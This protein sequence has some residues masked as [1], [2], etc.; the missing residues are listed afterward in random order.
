MGFFGTKQP[1]YNFSF[2]DKE[3]R[4]V[5]DDFAIKLDSNEKNILE[6]G[7][8]EEKIQTLLQIRR[9]ENHYWLEF[10]RTYPVSVFVVSPQREVLEWN[11]Y[12]EILTKWNHNELQNVSHA[13]EILWPQNPKECKVCKIVGKYDTKEK[14][15]GFDYAELEDKNGTIIPVF[16][17]VI[18]IFV[19][20]RLDRTYCII[21]DRREEISQRKEFLNSEIAPIVSRLEGL[22]QK[23]IQALISLKSDSELTALQEPIND[24]IRTLQDIINKIQNAATTIN[25]E[26]STAKNTLD[27]SVNWAQSEFQPTQADL[28]EKAKSLE[29]LTTDIESMVN[30]IK[31]IADQT[32]LLALNAAIEAARAGEHGR[33]FAVV[34]DEVRKLAENSHKSTIEITSSIS[35]IKDASF[36]MV[37]D[38]QKANDDTQKLIDELTAV[39]SNVNNIDVNILTL[40]EEVDTFKQ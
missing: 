39:H 4:E 28:V 29:N 6:N 20:S 24:I 2:L 15:A 23:D 5:V 14:K 32:N 27:S 1:A 16:V 35:M 18:P 17:Y 22:R 21:R 26:S 40:K 11:N 31:D 37:N 33:G 13:S 25:Q 9:R 10:K 12:F 38:I 36:S 19:N 8:I 7:N 3:I 34:A 30:I